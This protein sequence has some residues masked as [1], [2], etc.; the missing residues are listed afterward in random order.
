LRGN[1]I[2]P[3]ALAQQSIA[4]DV[5]NGIKKCLLIVWLCD[6]GGLLERPRQIGPLGGRH[7]NERDLPF[8]ERLGHTEALAAD[9]INV[10]QGAIE[11]VIEMPIGFGQRTQRIGNLVPLGLKDR[12]QIQSDHRIVFQD[13]NAHAKPL[14]AGPAGQLPEPK[15]LLESGNFVPAWKQ[16]VH[17]PRVP[18]IGSAHR[19]FEKSGLTPCGLRNAADRAPPL[20]ISLIHS[21]LMINLVA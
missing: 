21:Y 7:E 16:P 13:Q 17:G 18:E 8:D 2:L 12:L 10:E 14:L 19:R 20:E 1:E 9:H 6:E 11:T 15:S 4:C 5:A 3:D